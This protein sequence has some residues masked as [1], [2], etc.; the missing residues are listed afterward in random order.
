MSLREK[1]ED[2]HLSCNDRVARKLGLWL[3]NKK[4]ISPKKL[5]EV[6]KEF[7]RLLNLAEFPL[8]YEVFLHS[9]DEEGRIR[10]SILD[11]KNRSFTISLIH[12]DSF[13]LE[14]R[15]I[16]INEGKENRYY[17]YNDVHDLI[18][19][20]REVGSFFIESFGK[21]SYSAKVIGEDKQID[22][23][24]THSYFGP[25]LHRTIINTEN[26]VACFLKKEKTFSL[27]LVD[28]YKKMCELLKELSQLSP[29]KELEVT[30]SKGKTITDFLQYHRGEITKL[31][32]T[33][34][35]RT[36]EVKNFDNYRVISK[37]S[38]GTIEVNQSPIE[39]L[40]SDIGKR[41]DEETLQK[42]IT[43]ELASIQREVADIMDLKHTLPSF[44]KYSIFN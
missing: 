33:K 43:E 4:I 36:L 21:S 44:N 34:D 30:F 27:S 11:A 10:G 37:S 26:S 35:G 39:E 2:I 32:V 41:M 15:M 29:I 9:I 28:F 13:S 7:R 31:I 8:F 12:N 25:V 23:S 14:S 38:I 42:Q 20:R 3:Y 40:V 1:K 6:R 17:T 19:Y 5:N 18:L 22:I 24:F 16:M